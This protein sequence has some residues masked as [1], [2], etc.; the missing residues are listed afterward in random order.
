MARDPNGKTMAGRVPTSAW[1]AVVATGA[2]QAVN[3]EG[4][5]HI[6]TPANGTAEPR[7]ECT[8]AALDN[9]LFLLGGRRRH[10][11]NVFDPA[12]GTW[13]TQPRLQKELHHAQALPY[14][15]K[16]YLFGAMKGRYPREQALPYV[17]IYDPADDAL[18]AGP[19]V[20]EGR[21]RGGGGAAIASDGKMYFVGG[22]TNGHVGGAVAWLDEYDPDTGAWAALPDA[23]RPRD[24]FGAAILGGELYAAGGRTTSQGT[25]QAL[26]LV[27]S[28]V[29]AYSLEARRWRTIAPTIP[30]PRAGVAAVVFSGRLLVIGGE[31][32]AH[33]YAHLEV[34]AYDPR[35]DSWERLAPLAKGIHGTCA[36][37]GDD[38]IFVAAGATTRGGGSWRPE[39]V[40]LVQAYG[41]GLQVQTVGSRFMTPMH[42]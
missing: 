13:R 12:T 17:A 25:R 18:S 22:L 21:R 5:W 30:T 15:H 38:R 39:E 14:R 27:I 28:E 6:I 40:G 3:A 31:S 34:E 10:H 35:R 11:V 23:P 37:L 24:H 29:D 26:D 42:M 41:S 36:A 20:P 8:F 2:A 4:T 1:V 9:R 33:K 16:L 7:H 32:L 19:S